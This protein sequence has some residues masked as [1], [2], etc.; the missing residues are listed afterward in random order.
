MVVSKICAMT[1]M[2]FP[3]VACSHDIANPIKGNSGLAAKLAKQ[4]LCCAAIV[5]A[6]AANHGVYNMIVFQPPQHMI[7]QALH[8]M[9]LDHLLDSIM[10]SL[11]GFSM[12]LSKTK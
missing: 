8:L 4:L 11:I 1:S 9:L 2:N 10:T 6:R 3:A 5:N 12:I 7:N